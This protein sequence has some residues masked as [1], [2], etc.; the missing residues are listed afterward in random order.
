MNDVTQIPVIRKKIREKKL[1]YAEL[2]SLAT[3]SG[4]IRYD[5]DRVQT[6]IA[7]NKT[8]SLIAEY[9]EVEEEIKYLQHKLQ[10]NLDEFS[11]VYDLM[12]DDR[13]KM[14][15]RMRYVEGVKDL[16]GAF[17]CSRWTLYRLNIVA[18]K[19]YRDLRQK[20]V[21]FAETNI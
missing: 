7:G 13:E 14:Y 15:L 11:F 9:I 19:N 2:K 8:E 12:H 1:Q 3:N 6:S 21:T 5:K 4:T 20:Y 16:T 17:E 10:E 18:L